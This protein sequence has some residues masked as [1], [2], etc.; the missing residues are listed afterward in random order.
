VSVASQTIEL[1]SQPLFRFFFR[2]A[3]GGLPVKR[4][5]RRLRPRAN[6]YVKK[7]LFGSC[8]KPAISCLKALAKWGLGLP[9]EVCEPSAVQKLSSCSIRLAQVS[10][11]AACKADHRRNQLGGPLFLFSF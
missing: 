4:A 7:A 11:D 2:F 9:A 8:P 6:V 10:S 5:L 1:I 3:F